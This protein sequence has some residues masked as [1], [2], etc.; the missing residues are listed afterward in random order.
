M[1]FYKYKTKKEDLSWKLATAGLLSHD[2]DVFNYDDDED[3][4][5]DEDDIGYTSGMSGFNFSRD[6]NKIVFT[7]FTDE[8]IKEDVPMKEQMANQ[9]RKILYSKRKSAKMFYKE[10]PDYADMPFRYLE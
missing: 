4:E 1:F 7:E 10:G 3:G 6:D 8:K 2:I 9:L 5:D